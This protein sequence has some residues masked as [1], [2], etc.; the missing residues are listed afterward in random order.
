MEFQNSNKLKG[1]LKE[2]SNRLQIHSN[3]IYTMYFI[4]E[5]LKKLQTN[6]P[7]LYFI[8]GSVS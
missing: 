2:E 7:D 6:D 4:R 8:K 3:N 1:Y 5:F